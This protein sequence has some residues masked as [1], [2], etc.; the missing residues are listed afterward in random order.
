MISKIHNERF[1]L[2]SENIYYKEFMD[3]ISKNLN[4]PLAKT[5]LTKSILHMIYFF[6]S[7][8]SFLRL[9]KRF[10]SKA[11]ISTLI[12]NQEFDGRKIKNFISFEYEKIDKKIKEICKDF[13]NN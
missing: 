2:V 10:M 12:S 9:K 11:L 13:I 1:I 5:P 8:L 4:K 7:I 6:D 3:L